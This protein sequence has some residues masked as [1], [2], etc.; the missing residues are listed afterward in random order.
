MKILCTLLL[1]A[2][3]LTF[4]S[5]GAEP[6]T[7][8]K[9]LVQERIIFNWHNFLSGC[10]T[11]NFEDWQRWTKEA[12]DMGYNA[13]MVHAYG[14]NPMAA[15]DFQGKQRPVGYLTTTAKGRDWF[16]VHVNDVRRTVGGEVFDGPVFGS[17]AAMVPD[18]ERVKSAQGLMQQVFQDAAQ[19]GMGIYF[20]VDVDTA[21]SNQ[22]E[23][24][25][26][27]PESARFKNEEGLWLANPDTPEG[28]A[29]YKAAVSG[30][31]KTYPQITKL[32][33][34]ARREST[35]WGGIDKSMPASWREEYNT[36]MAKVPE[37]KNYWHASSLFALS[38]VVRAFERALK[39]CG[40]TNTRLG[41]GS[42]GFAFL[43]A[44]DLFFAKDVTFFGKDYDV[45][46]DKAQLATPERRA[47][48]AKV[49]AHRQVIPIIW[50]HHD[51]G[52]YL[53]RPYTPFSDFY[54]KLTES[55]TAGFGVIH[56]M[57]R[58]FDLYLYSHIRQ[59][60]S[61]TLNEPLRTTCQHYAAEVLKEPEL[62]EYI[63]RWATEAPLF[64]RETTDR[65]TQWGVAKP[66]WP[67]SKKDEIIAGCRDR[68]KLLEKAQGRHATYFKGLEKF[69]IAF[70]EAETAIQEAEAA[71]KKG[72]LA[73][74]RAI[75]AA[76]RPE[77]AV[78]RLAAFTNDGQMTPGEK[79]LLHSLNTRWLIYFTRMRQILG[80]EPI[81]I[82]FGP[83][84]HEQLA[85]GPG[86][87][88]YFYDADHQVWQT[89]GTEE[90]KVEIFDAPSVDKE[91][92]RSGLVSE[93]PFQ[94]NARPIGNPTNLRTGKYRLRLL[95]VDP[96]SIAEGQRVFKVAVAPASNAQD[97]WNFQPVKATQLR[98]KL[99]G[100]DVNDWNSIYEVKLA[101]LVR[102]VSDSV[103][104]SAAEK[105]TPASNLID[106]K[107]N[108]RWSAKG[109]D[110]WVQFRIDPKVET[111]EI[112]VTWFEADSRVAKFEM[113]TSQDGK[114]WS[115]VADLRRVEEKPET[116]FTVDVF[117][118]AGKANS[119]TEWEV[120]VNLAQHGFVKVTLTPVKGKALISGMVLESTGSK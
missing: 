25:T 13:I 36:T 111:S 29:Y 50:A 40:A 89:Y 5:F 98:L 54:S 95:F 22:Q 93:K 94:V 83:T 11:W 7:E 117:Q 70:Y 102:D 76:S 96:D 48:L 2:C 112:G 118:K 71:W 120:P 75:I 21:Q 81:R 86:R 49:G 82:N 66:E 92:G 72:D 87:F 55:K 10:S 62:S 61:A 77:E 52:H 65:F 4:P 99:H 8:N 20:A 64:G 6:A 28:Y 97:K 109:R 104:V 26:L 67:L 78:R 88:T 85:Q 116:E 14:N 46:Y 107:R 119:L 69:V 91:I 12:H 37:A 32:V 45:L 27:L 24:I 17:K 34:W 31:M 16:T 79:G 113:E 114:Q 39:E 53:A 57:T 74:A 68:M 30:W 35:A 38:K 56:W 18:E 108:T 44:A 9:P 15:F 23:L 59:V 47:E 3:A 101:S 90:T 51:D 115:P 100:T 103:T 63:Y 105:G 33:V 1:V 58:P 60:S 110:H 42:W 73:A 41:F 80:L 19:R 43:P 84:Q 106:G